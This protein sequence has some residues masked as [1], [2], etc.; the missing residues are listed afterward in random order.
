MYLTKKK[1]LLGSLIGAGVVVSL[2]FVFLFVLAIVSVFNGL[3]PRSADPADIAQ[4]QTDVTFALKEQGLLSPEATLSFIDTSYF[5]SGIGENQWWLQSSATVPVDVF[6]V[7]GLARAANS[8]STVESAREDLW[9]E[10]RERE[11]VVEERLAEDFTGVSEG[12][13]PSMV[14]FTDGVLYLRDCT[15]IV[16]PEYA[17]DA[18]D[19][20]RSHCDTVN[21]LANNY[22]EWETLMRALY[23]RVDVFT[24]MLTR[25]LPDS[26]RARF[27]AEPQAAMELTCLHDVTRSVG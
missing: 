17:M 21:N 2:P 24:E 4:A 12:D 5:K 10:I 18:P 13:L 19:Y 22:D 9:R 8:E 27:V 6:T 25:A 7:D 26:C 14:Y 16:K 15:L 3:I 1:A 11:D 20:V 23:G